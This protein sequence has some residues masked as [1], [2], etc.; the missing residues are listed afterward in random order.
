[1]QES[2][3]NELLSRITTNPGIFGGKPIIRG[4]RIAV[5]HVL[6]SLAAGET[7]ESLLAE[8]PFLE[9]DDIRAC[10]IYASTR[11]KSA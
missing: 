1:M 11:P 9:Q 5:E 3:E 4:M 10:L 2:P 7:P 8:Y 6:A